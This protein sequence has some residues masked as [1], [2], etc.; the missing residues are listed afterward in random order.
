MGRGDLDI[1]VVHDIDVLQVGGA[2]CRSHCT[3]LSRV[4]GAKVASSSLSSSRG[5]SSVDID[6]AVVRVVVVIV[7]FIV[8]VVNGNYEKGCYKSQCCI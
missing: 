6:V 4:C 5:F 8:F 3:F 2:S 1:H 7:F